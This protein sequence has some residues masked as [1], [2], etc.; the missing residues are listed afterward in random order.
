MSGMILDWSAAREAGAACAGGKGWQLGVL[1]DLGL[2]VP[3]GFVIAAEASA[4]HRCG[5]PLP[6]PVMDALAHALQRH[7]WIDQPL[8]VRSSAVQEDSGYA[9]FAGMHRSCLNVR[10]LDA[11]A[12]AVQ[13]VWDSHGSPEAVAY[14][15]RLGIVDRVAAMAVVVMPLLPAVASGI[16]F[17]CDPLSG[18]RDQ[19]L[20]HAN[21][22]LG[23]AL[24]SGQADGDEYRLQEAGDDARLVLID[25]RVGGKAR[26]SAAAEAGG[27]ALQDTPAQQAAQAVLSTDQV[28]ALGEIVREVANVLDYANPHY[29]VE[30][31]WDGHRHWVVQARPVTVTGR[32]TYSALAGQPTIWSRGNSRDV[33]PDPLSP[34]DVSRTTFE[35]ILTRTTALAGYPTLPG[36]QR[37]ALHAGRIY[38]DASIMQWEAFDAFGAEPKAINELLGGHHPEIAVPAPTLKQK[39]KRLQYSLRFIRRITGPR[40]RAHRLIAGV[41]KDAAERLMQSLPPDNAALAS[42]LREQIAR[43]RGADDLFLLWAAGSA[44]YALLDGIEKYCP[45]ES[46]GLA[47]ALMARGKPS[48]TAEQGYAL[49][50]LS[51]VAATDPAARAWL[52][53]QDLVASEWAQQLPPDSAFRRAFETFMREYGHRAIYE[54]Y[55]RNPRWRESPGYLLQSIVG[56]MGCDPA[57]GRERQ[58][59]AWM[60]A[61]RRLS[62]ALPWHFRLLLPILVRFATAERNIREASRSAYVA[63][64]EVARRLTLA[65]AQR[66]AARGWTNEDDI[67]NLTL[68]EWLSLAEGRLPIAV[69]TKRAAWRRAQLEVFAAHPKPEVIIEKGGMAFEQHAPD[70]QSADAH[71]WSGIAVGGGRATGAAHVAHEPGEA[72]GM[73]VGAVLVAPSTDPAW[74]PQF[75]KAGALVMETG[76]YLSHGAIVARE[77]G[78]PAVVNLPGILGHIENG[79]VLDVD[80]NRGRVY[81]LAAE[82]MVA[83]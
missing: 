28:I 41:R 58:Q 32:Y 78:I 25:R 10:G 47:A 82:G 20:I 7:G 11:V 31:V 15:Q 27:T 38:Y 49:L 17:T 1:A 21:W 36:I 79:D 14:R 9:S 26:F 83:G 74:T 30:W 16:A 61:R 45:G 6:A 19:W 70:I 80:G 59:Q 8:A 54:S 75:L 12:R 39:L 5:D 81:R 60:A 23:E 63:Q 76:G 67:F 4:G 46:H 22:G 35:R 64:L 24:V 42:G 62:K 71:V 56:L 3:R 37:I 57:A 50:E 43:M 40:L 66:M 48:V 72:L 69:A 51:R 53:S 33:V 77:F 18:R 52:Q 44:L 73:P 29:D 65:L 34:M 55:L 68:P 13:Q 2:P